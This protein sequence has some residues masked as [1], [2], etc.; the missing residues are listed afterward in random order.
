MYKTSL[1]PVPSCIFERPDGTLFSLIEGIH[2]ER[3][4]YY[5]S[6]FSKGDCG[7]S[8]EKPLQDHDYGTWKCIASPNE[9]LGGFVHIHKN[10]GMQLGREGIKITK[11][12]YIT[13]ASR[14]VT[15]IT[16]STN[17]PIIKTVKAKPIAISCDAKES[18]AYCYAKSPSGKMYW[19]TTSGLLIGQCK[20]QINFHQ[21]DNG[22]WICGMGVQGYKAGYEDLEVKIE[23]HVFGKC[24]LL[25]HLKN[26]VLF[27]RGKL[28]N[29][30]FF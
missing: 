23:V 25:L 20:V 13:E 14:S 2:Y 27:L 16:K 18:L 7:V 19:S 12:I 15:D 24:A 29:C 4:S 17:T 9:K 8:I 21:A 1:S 11:M 6:G 10:K 5:G 3:Y 28:Y 26:R 30:D 22:T